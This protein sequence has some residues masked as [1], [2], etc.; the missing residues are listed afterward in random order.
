MVWFSGT[1]PIH[2]NLVVVHSKSSQLAIFR[3]RIILWVGNLQIK[4]DL[5]YTTCVLKKQNHKIAFLGP[6]T[7][8]NLVL[9]YT[10]HMSWYIR[11]LLPIIANVWKT[12]HS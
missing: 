11:K 6:R 9:L 3:S 5:L 8:H 12:I 1:W 10:I 2:H 7:H 4:K